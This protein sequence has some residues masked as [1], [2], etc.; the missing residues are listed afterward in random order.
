MAD[1]AEIALYL[2][3]QQWAVYP[4]IPLG[5]SPTGNCTNGCGGRRTDRT[6]PGG[7]GG[8][9]CTRAINPCHGVHSATTDLDLTAARWDQA[10]RANPALHLGLS[11]L[12][13]LDVDCHG[14]EPPAELAPGLA[15]PGVSNGVGAFAV[16]LDH[17]G[18]TWPE[19]TL[20]VETPTGGLHIYYQA[21]KIALRT[22]LAA[23][24]VEVKAGPVSITAPGAIRR[25][26]D[27][28]IGTYRRMSEAFTPGPFPT[29]LGEWLVSIGRVADPHR[30][31]SV[32]QAPRWSRRSDGHTSRWWEKAWREQLAEI[33]NAP[34]GERNAVVKRRGPRLFN[35]ANEPGCP[36]TADDAERA[37]IQ[38]QQDYSAATGRRPARH[39]EYEDVAEAVREFARTPRGS[40][41]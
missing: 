28:T 15:N 1:L 33:A 14:D 39:R 13:V 19:D 21:P 31:R 17:L 24:Q 5:N 32:D 4:Q 34:A 3:R 6:C 18:V 12:A 35:L 20:I 25:L 11:N 7:P 30:P 26:D 9:P 23:W 29:W 41:A 27:G 38:A 22:T 16:L 36:W 2:A 8:C 37:L 10:P 40:A